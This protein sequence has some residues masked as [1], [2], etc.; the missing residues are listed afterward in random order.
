MSLGRASR[1][2]IPK[3]EGE[4]LITYNEACIGDMTGHYATGCRNKDTL[5][6]F[7]GMPVPYDPVARMPSKIQLIE[8]DRDILILYGSCYN[9]MY[10]F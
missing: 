9:I 3:I 2:E 6:V 4:Y 5:G 10:T 8:I 1:E 7:V